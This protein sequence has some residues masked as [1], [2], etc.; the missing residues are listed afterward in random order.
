MKGGLEK[1]QEFA[2][3]TLMCSSDFL[4]ADILAESSNALRSEGSKACGIKITVGIPMPLK[5]SKYAAG[6]AFSKVA[7][8]IVVERD[9]PNA[10]H[11]PSAVY[12]AERLSRLFH[13]KTAPVECGYGKICLAD[14]NP[15]QALPRPDKN[16]TAIAVNFLAQS[17]LG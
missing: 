6:P 13:G 2:A 14:S 7:L 3:K 11:S 16:T 5:A 17:V 15:W 12:L 9:N 1:L 4:C 10:A 8:Q